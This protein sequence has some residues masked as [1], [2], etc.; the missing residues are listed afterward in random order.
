MSYFLSVMCLAFI[1]ISV[2]ASHI[3]KRKKIITKAAKIK[4]LGISL[5]AVILAMIAL[6]F[7]IH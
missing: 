1:I 3:A 5:A 4:L 7:Q 6:Y 2:I